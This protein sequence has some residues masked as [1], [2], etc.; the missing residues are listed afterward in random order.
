M[1]VLV[2]IYRM[3]GLVV[4]NGVLVVVVAD[5]MLALLKILVVTCAQASEAAALHALCFAVLSRV[6]TA[7]NAE[8]E[9]EQ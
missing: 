3:L 8:R 7:R 5:K 1:L 2:V 4:T 9:E 6:G